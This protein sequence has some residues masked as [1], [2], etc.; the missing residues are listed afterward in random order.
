MA[1]VQPS[2]PFVHTEERGNG[3]EWKQSTPPAGQVKFLMSYALNPGGRE[4]YYG[5]FKIVGVYADELSAEK[6]NLEESKKDF[7]KQ[8]KIGTMGKWD[9]LKDP[10][11]LSADQL[12]KIVDVK[13]K[14]GEMVKTI[15]STQNAI[16]K[17]QE[18]RDKKEMKQREDKILSE[19]ADDIE[20]D[21]DDDPKNKK[22]EKERYVDYKILREKIKQNP[23]FIRY[24][25]EQ[26]AELEKEIK[27]VEEKNLK[28][29]EDLSIM[30]KTFPDLQIR[31]KKDQEENAKK[32]E[33]KIKK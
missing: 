26:I 11:R 33:E 15:I 20:D 31:Y 5:A 10:I 30:D 27:R 1:N 21:E 9:L 14:N 18:D 19:M 8:Y 25:K 28:A 22:K 6:A 13:G 12:D 16:I 32:K 4:G 24:A 17:K 2:S 23:D 7:N 3:I 29:V